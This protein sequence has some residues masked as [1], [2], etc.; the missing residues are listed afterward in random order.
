MTSAIA[1]NSPPPIKAAQNVTNVNNRSSAA[2]CTRQL[3]VG[4][5]ALHCMHSGGA[6]PPRPLHTQLSHGDYV[7]K[8]A[9]SRKERHNY[10][11]GGW[12]RVAYFI[13]ML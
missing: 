8:G 13:C 9:R 2:P 1:H 11:L 12:Q 3:K 4:I 5:A 10:L 6:P 7:H